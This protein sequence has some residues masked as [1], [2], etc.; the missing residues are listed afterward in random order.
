M[1]AR[2]NPNI[3]KPLYTHAT[4]HTVNKLKIHAGPIYKD[5]PDSFKSGTTPENKH[6]RDKKPN[7]ATTYKRGFPADLFTYSKV[8]TPL[9]L[10][11]SLSLS[12]E[13]K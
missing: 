13:R 1:V 5:G 7:F 10:S 3:P 8:Q 2:G 9:S 6:H 12:L 11:L 4:N